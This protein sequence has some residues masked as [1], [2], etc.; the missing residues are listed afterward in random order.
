MAWSV[1]TG[2]IPAVADAGIGGLIAL[3]VLLGVAEGL[4]LPAVHSML[5]VYIQS[6]SSLHLH[7]SSQLPAT[8]EASGKLDNTSVN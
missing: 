2:L 4:A 3:R 6:I 1:C 5:S 7:Q 8:Q